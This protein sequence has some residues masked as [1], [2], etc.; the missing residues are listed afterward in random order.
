MSGLRISRSGSWQGTTQV[1][2]MESNGS[3][4]LFVCSRPARD[5]GDFDVQADE[6]YGNLYDALRTEGARPEDVITEKV[7]FS[8]VDS[9]FHDLRGIRHECYNGRPSSAEQVPATLFLHQPP[10]HPG[11]LCELQAYALFSTAEAD[12]SVRTIN[13]APGL[14]SGKVIDHKGYRHLYLMNLTGGDGPGDG[15]DFSAQAWDMFKR[16]EMLLERE[17]LS[18][19]E[20]ARTWIYINDIER[21]YSAFNAVRTQFFQERG[22]ARL[23]ASTGIQGATYP[24]ERGC[25]MDL[26]T[27]VEQH[28]GE[29][30]LNLSV[31][32]AH[33]LNEAPVYG[34]AFSRGMR[35]ELADRVVL[36]ISGTA[37]IDTSGTVLCVGDIEGQVN[38][39]LLNVEKLLAAQGASVSDL[40]TAITYLKR[41]D[42]LDTFFRVC[43]ERGLPGGLLNTVS[44][45][46]ICRPEWLCEIEAVAIL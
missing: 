38:R 33:T 36:Y 25:T 17:G 10:C 6:M 28:P 18:F 27:V 9:Q 40:V 21:D 41:P 31:M 19:R 45:A 32:H 44:V 42:Y 1:T 5:A 46:D 22:V 7:F 8:D 37:S 14:A 15:M 34:S 11:R 3:V 12:T 4:E 39:M 16:A 23:P 13:G 20:V 24:K 30:P 43:R 26:Y 2:R 29:R 35:V